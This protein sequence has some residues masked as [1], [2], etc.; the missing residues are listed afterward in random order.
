MPPK[1]R[2]ISKEVAQEKL[3]GENYN[4]FDLRWRRMVLRM[5]AR[6]M[7]AHHS[8][9]LKIMKIPE[10][11]NKRIEAE[12]KKMQKGEM[13]TR[14]MTKHPQLPTAISKL[15]R[16]TLES[17]LN[18][19]GVQGVSVKNMSKENMKDVIYAIPASAV[20]GQVVIDV[21]EPEKVIIQVR[22]K[23]EEKASSS[24]GPNMSAVL[25]FLRNKNPAP[26][27]TTE[28]TM[29]FGLHKGAN[30]SEVMCQEPK[31]TVWCLKT[32]AKKG[33]LVSTGMKDFVEYVKSA[34][35]SQM[36]QLGDPTP[37]VELM[38]SDEESSAESFCMEANSSEE[39]GF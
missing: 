1:M 17:I 21:G 35:E 29:M 23:N 36:Q 14:R 19:F 11:R 9:L 30:Y 33:W 5:F 26:Q 8:Q 31:Y 38:A 16:S 3:K 20:K 4:L 39:G 13:T 28:N 18:D 24:S 15:P 34:A 12:V 7:W 37:G 10:D 2:I 32:E 25:K 27:A 22:K 6:R